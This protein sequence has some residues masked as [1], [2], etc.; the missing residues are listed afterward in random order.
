MQIIN[1]GKNRCPNCG[2]A[3]VKKAKGANSKWLSLIE[4]VLNIAS[5]CYGNKTANSVRWKCES[6]GC[7]WDQMSERVL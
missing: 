1:R 3:D 5:I 2:S 7:L 4:A 6:C